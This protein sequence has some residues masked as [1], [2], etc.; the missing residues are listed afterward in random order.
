MAEYEIKDTGIKNDTE[1]TSA[2]ARISYE[3][4]NAKYIDLKNRKIKEQLQELQ[5]K[6]KFPANLEFIDAFYDKKTSLSSVAFKDI[7]TG[8]V[9][10]G[11]A[12]TNLDNGFWESFQDL[13]ADAQIAL[14]G[15]S[16]T[17]HSK[18]EDWRTL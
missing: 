13:K 14:S 1:T 7:S 5:D 16:V 10:V 15:E 12:G 4:E 18:K 2:I 3:I 11:F 6:N 8:K 9:T 17:S